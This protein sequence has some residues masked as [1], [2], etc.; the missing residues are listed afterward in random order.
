MTNRGEKGLFCLYL[1]VFRFGTSNREHLHFKIYSTYYHEDSVQVD[2]ISVTINYY[3][4]YEVVT[5]IE[6]SCARDFVIKI[7]YSIIFPL[8]FSTDLLLLVAA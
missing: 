8:F 4:I 2:T 1:C 7:R 6:Y 3:H 5:F